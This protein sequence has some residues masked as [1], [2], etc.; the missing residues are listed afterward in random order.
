MSKKSSFEHPSAVP[1]WYHLDRAGAPIFLE[2]YLSAWGKP[3][4]K[5]FES[6]YYPFQK[7]IENVS[8]LFLKERMYGRWWNMEETG[9]AMLSYFSSKSNFQTY[10]QKK[11]KFKREVENIWL[12]YSREKIGKMSDFE[13]IGFFQLVQELNVKSWII[14]PAAPF[15]GQVATRYSH[16]WLEKK[17]ITGE[18]EK[19]AFHTLFAFDKISP[20][21]ARQIYIKEVLDT[22]SPTKKSQMIT[23]LAKRFAYSKTEFGGYQHYTE[24]DVMKEYDL[25]KNLNIN[26]KKDYNEKVELLYK[27]GASDFEK[28][29][30]YVFG[31]TTYN[32][33]ERRAYQ[34]KI[35][36]LID[37]TLAEMA[38]R[39]NISLDILRY[40]LTKEISINNL[41][42]KSFHHK[43]KLRF[44]KGSLFYWKKRKSSGFLIGKKAHDFFES[45]DQIGNI[46]GT[47]QINGQSAYYGLVR[48][49]ALIVK[50]IKIREPSGPFVLVAGMTSPEYIQ[51]MQKAIAIVTDEG[52][53]S[54]HAA[55]LSREL[56]KP[57]IV[58][59]KIATKVLK[60]GDLVEVD[61]NKG[62]VT[63]LKKAI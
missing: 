2:A 58:G 5:K 24:E 31:Y 36:T 45:L 1:D 37:W 60:D 42:S 40:A 8:L 25:A 13:L 33:D 44:D 4:R 12:H 50:D 53:I 49:K 17:G 55:I 9:Y 3:K 26:T 48:G 35:F 38:F 51:L 41:K 10:I 30:F 21:L 16:W 43:I 54:C 56:K 6:F 47:N 57:C 52:G 27:L 14:D 46:D 63:I 34:Q 23:Q 19:K 28:H 15:I 7:N 22:I 62:I 18:K 32:R 11:E 61:A 59:T 39:Y 29:I 20:T